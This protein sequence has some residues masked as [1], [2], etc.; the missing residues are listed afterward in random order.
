VDPDDEP[1]NQLA[2]WDIRW[3]SPIGDWNYAL[4]NQHTGETID[5]S[6]PRPYRNFDVVGLE[7]WGSDATD[8]SSWRA[9]LEWANTRCGGTVDGQKLWDC[10]YNNG[11]FNVE[12]YRSKGRPLGHSMD[13][14]GQMYSLRFVRVDGSATSGPAAL[15]RR[16]RGHRAGYAPYRGARAGGGGAWTSVTISLAAAGSRRA[17]VW[18][19]T[20]SERLGGARPCLGV[21]GRVPLSAPIGARTGAPMQAPAGRETD[22]T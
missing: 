3:A 18:A 6:I 13:G 12:G 21:G 17:R 20:A 9:S 19:T 15:H 5:N 11:I 10:A 1:G 8:G 16:E 14:D 2:G 7:T 22:R 4:Y